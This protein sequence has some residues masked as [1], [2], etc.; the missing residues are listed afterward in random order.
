MSI[1]LDAY[2][3]RIGYRGPREATLAVL[4]DVHALHVATIPFEN[5]DAFAGVTPRLDAAGLEAK[6]LHAGRGGW[7]FEHNH[8]LLH[9]LRAL[10]FDAHGL[11][12]RV[13]WNQAPGARP[14]RT[15]MLLQVAIDGANWLADVGFGRLAL[16]APLRFATGVTQA[17]PHEPFR[18]VSSEEG[19]V[20]QAR[21]QG[22]WRA[23]YAFDLQ[24]QQQVDF[25]VTNWY[26]ANNPASP[27]VQ[28]LTACRTLPGRRVGLRDRQLFDNVV[29]RCGAGGSTTVRELAS[30]AELKGVL[31]DTFG[32]R[33]PHSET[34]ERR[35]AGLFHAPAYS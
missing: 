11:A 28:A 34:L 23:L 21:L 7:C 35:L 32:I 29:D 26:L 18:L 13:L 14:A 24:P 31:S 4:A 9:V 6:L 15:H 25:E 1:D 5:L 22:D 3:A 20:L 10:G 19:L 33:L 30:V 2:C 27:F 16:A 12:A 17:T 8:L